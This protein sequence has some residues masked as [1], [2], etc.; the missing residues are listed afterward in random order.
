MIYSFFFIFSPVKK[1]VIDQDLQAHAEGL[2]ELLPA[3]CRH[4]T[5][6]FQVFGSVAQLM[7]DFL[8]K[9]SFMHECIVVALKVIL[10]LT[11]YSGFLFL[12]F[13]FLHK[14]LDTTEIWDF[15]ATCMCMCLMFIC[16]FVQTLVDENKSVLVSDRDVCQSDSSSAIDSVT[17]F[18]TVPSY[19]KKAARKNIK[20]LASH[21]SN[22]LQALSD[23]FI[24]S[25]PGKR[26]VLKVILSC[27]QFILN[28]WCLWWKASCVLL[29]FIPTCRT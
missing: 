25:L 12:L 15:Y 2:W 27:L 11:Y 18:R 28:L 13:P 10:L 26:T 9:D 14:V 24:D 7:I 21:S 16:G 19:S 8:K 3:F 29:E 6:T 1:S 17:D 20:V 22:L 23:L 4:S 5:D